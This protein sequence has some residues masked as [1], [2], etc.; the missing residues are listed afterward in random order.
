ML[1]TETKLPLVST[2]SSWASFESDQ[3]PSYASQQPV[4]PGTVPNMTPTLP[5]RSRS[6]GRNTGISSV[7]AAESQRRVRQV[8]RAVD[9]ANAKAPKRNAEGVFKSMCSTDVLFLIDTTSSM[10]DYIHAAKDQVQS[11]ISRIQRTFLGESKV[12]VAVV[13]YKDHCND[14]T[15]SFSTSPHRLIMQKSFLVV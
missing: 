15:L 10:G 12:R 11:I 13:G 6:S 9:K 8:Q 5:V 14:P 2:M 7:S 3:P 4:L 1:K